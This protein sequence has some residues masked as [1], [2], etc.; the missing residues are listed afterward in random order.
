[1]KI[2]SCI[3]VAL[4]FA[5]APVLASDTILC[6]STTS[7]TDGPTLALTGGRDTGIVRARLTQ[8]GAGF[9]TGADGPAIAQAWVDDWQLK[10]DIVDANAEGRIARLDTRRRAGTSYIGILIYRG[11][12]WRVRCQE[13]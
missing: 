7:P 5:A 2:A 12:T 1:M 10:L 8:N 4:S 13:G 3:A 11:R 9:T 6:R